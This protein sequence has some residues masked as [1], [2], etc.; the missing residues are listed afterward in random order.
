VPPESGLVAR[1]LSMLCFGIKKKGLD[2]SHALLTWCVGPAPP[3]PS[4][5]VSSS[6]ST[7]SSAYS[8]YLQLIRKYVLCYIHT[9]YSRY[10]LILITALAIATASS[11]RRIKIK[12]EKQPG[13]ICGAKNHQGIVS[14][15]SINPRS[16]LS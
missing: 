16:V 6:P 14:L 3:Y 7:Y 11:S 13:G 4:L 2:P 10:D 12:K 15:V 1:P 8:I 5:P 9:V